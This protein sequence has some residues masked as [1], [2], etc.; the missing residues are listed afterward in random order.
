MSFLFLLKVG[1]VICCILII[2]YY[3]HHS[4]LFQDELLSPKTYSFTRGEQTIELNQYEFA[5]SKQLCIPS[6]VEATVIGH[7][8]IL[9][10]VESIIQ[11]LRTHKNTS[12][13]IIEPPNGILLYGPPGT[14]KTTIAKSIAQRFQDEC[15]F[16]HIS[17]EMIENKYY[18]EGLKQLTAIFSL[19]TKVKPCVLFFDEI[20]GFM[21]KRSGMDQTHTNTMKTSFLTCMDS[22][23]DEWNVLLIATTNRKECLDPALLRRLDVQLNMGLP[24]LIDKTSFL[25]KYIG[26]I[27]PKA[28]NAFCESAPLESICDYKNFCKYCVRTYLNGGSQLVD[29]RLDVNEKLLKQYLNQYISLQYTDSNGHSDDESES[30]TGEHSHSS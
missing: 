25:K 5:M 24:S 3:T 8:G 17:P 20:D 27:D 16:I 19:A 11:L 10:E 13:T 12:S 21:S 6:S 18:G 26:Q 29:D 23:Q 14:G 15:Y 1:Y 7:A 30:G 2:Y 22:L 4:N 28:L 9:R